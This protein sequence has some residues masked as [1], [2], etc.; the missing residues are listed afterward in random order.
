MYCIHRQSR[1]NIINKQLQTFI[2]IAM[3]TEILHLSRGHGT[4]C[5]RRLRL[6]GAKITTNDLEMNSIEKKNTCG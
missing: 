2:I 3:M 1:K 4:L 5:D 6:F